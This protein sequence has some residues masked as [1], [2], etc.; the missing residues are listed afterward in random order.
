MMLEA[1]AEG[2]GVALTDE[3]TDEIVDRLAV[4]MTDAE[5]IRIVLQRLGDVE[6]QALAFVAEQGQVRAHVMTRKYGDIRRLGPGRLEWQKAWRDP[7][8]PVEHLWFLGLLHREYGLDSVYQ[9]EV[10]FVP[11]DL[12][13]ALPPMEIAL[14]AFHL[15]RVPKPP[16]ARDDRDAL[17][18][19][20]FAVLAHLRKNSVRGERGV[21][22]KHESVKLHPRLAGSELPK[23]MRFLHHICEEAGLILREDGVWRPTSEGALWL[24]EGPLARRRAL[25]HTWLEDRN[26]NDLCMVP[27]LVCEDTGWR[28]DPVLARR[29]LLDHLLK[30][31]TDAW[32]RVTSLVDSIHDVDPDFMRPDGDYKSWYIRDASTGHYLMGY[33]NWDKVEGALIRYFLEYPLCWLGVVAIGYLQGED[34][35]SCF[36]LTDSAAAIVGLHELDEAPLQGMVVLSNLRVTVPLTASWY[37]RYLLER[38]ARWEGEEH[39]TARYVIDDASV[40]ACL[41]RGVSVNQIRAF[42]RRATGDRVPAGALRRIKSWAQVEGRPGQR[43]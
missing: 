41:A 7:V 16:M 32:L 15:E 19:D 30:C 31:P 9:G 38:F 21:L 2:W 28:S 27:Q 10:F 26:W 34:R 3:Q 4:E 17:A 39:E 5:G 20:V 1:I 42:L 8:S 11:P 12:Q 29:G 22:A 18:R 25:Y 24:K 33:E 14:P 23:R 40:R 37:D 6:R 35:P 36:R 43:L 13:G